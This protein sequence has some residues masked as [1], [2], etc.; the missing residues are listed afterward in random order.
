MAASATARLV[1][2]TVSAIVLIWLVFGLR[3]YA[4]TSDGQEV[5]D[6]VQQ[7]PPRVEVTDGVQSLRDAQTLNAD[8]QPVVNEVLLLWQLGRLREATALG[9][10]LVADEPK[11]VEAWFALWATSLRAGDK[12]RG[13]EAFARLRALDPLR[14]RVLEDFR[15]TGSA[16]S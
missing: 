7:D 8:K 9:E 15:P 4:L 14:A 16:G 13:A 1:L 6:R 12:Q 11:N 3:A 5:L 10:Q 2:V